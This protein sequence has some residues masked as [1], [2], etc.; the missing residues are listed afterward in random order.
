MEN[1][2]VVDSGTPPT[3]ET[4]PEPIII[5]IDDSHDSSAAGAEVEAHNNPREL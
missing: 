5:I 2:E 1:L 3:L 4:K